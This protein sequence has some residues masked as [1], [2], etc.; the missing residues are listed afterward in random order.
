MIG[1]TLSSEE[2]S[3][4]RIDGEERLPSVP[5]PLSRF[6][7]STNRLSDE[8]VFEILYNPRRRYTMEFLH[9]R[10]RP[11]SMEELVE[12]IAATENGVPIGELDNQQCRRV[13]VSLYQTHLPM[14]DE[15]DA[16]EYDQEAQRIA[17]GPAATE[18]LPYLDTPTEREVPWRTYY[19]RLFLA[20]AAVG[21]AVAVGLVPA[22]SLLSLTFLGAVLFLA[23]AFLH[24]TQ[25]RT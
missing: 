20:Y 6:L 17:P 1:K 4:E 22:P 18:L 9:R 5:A 11:C 12:H 15:A 21:G 2:E 19:L 3:D 8:D 24:G 23:V 7:L 14:L 16:I 10:D 25:R 13:Y